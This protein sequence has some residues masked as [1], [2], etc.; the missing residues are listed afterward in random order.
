M[1]PAPDPAAVALVL[2]LVTQAAADYTAAVAAAPEAP[3]GPGY[4]LDG[5][6]SEN[7]D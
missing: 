1:F 7:I 4:A 2:A 5:L 6:P 3:A